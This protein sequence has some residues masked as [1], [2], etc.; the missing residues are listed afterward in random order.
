MAD[1]V[2]EIKAYF[3]APPRG[4]S[5]IQPELPDENI[6]V[7]MPLPMSSLATDTLP[8]AVACLPR[9]ETLN[10]FPAIVWKYCVQ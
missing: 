1:E 5:L 3:S 9:V 6:Q 7:E 8:P 10:E 4:S 2:I